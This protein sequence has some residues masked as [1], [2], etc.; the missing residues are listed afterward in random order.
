MTENSWN[1]REHN[2]FMLNRGDGSF[3]EIGAGVGLDGV[4]DA[5]GI[6]FADL[7]RDGDADLIVNNYKALAAYYVNGL[8]D[9]TNVVGGARARRK[10]EP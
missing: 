7:D 6:A 3:T 2:H 5:R 1:G 10:R 9:R 8:A 4:A